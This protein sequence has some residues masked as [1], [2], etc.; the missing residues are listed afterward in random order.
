MDYHPHHPLT[1]L[2]HP[3]PCS[4]G[5]RHLERQGGQGG[6]LPATLTTRLSQLT[7]LTLPSAWQWE[8]IGSPGSCS[9]FWWLCLSLDSLMLGSLMLLNLSTSSQNSDTRLHRYV[10]GHTSHH[11]SYYCQPL[12]EQR[13]CN[14]LGKILK[15]KVQQGIHVFATV[16]QG[17]P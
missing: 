8:N 11:G 4:Q 3:E 15:N 7:L 12:T 6:G 10:L 17:Q 16:H 5:L 2:P 9:F 14:A 1:E 13:P